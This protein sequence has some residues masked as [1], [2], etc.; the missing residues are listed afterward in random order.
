MTHRVDKVTGQL[1]AIAAE[2]LNRAAGTQSVVTVTHCEMP[3]DLKTAK[4]FISVFPESKE[5]EAL[6]FARRRRSELREVIAEKLPLKNLPF[7]EIEL[8]EGEKNR[9]KIDRLLAGR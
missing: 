4:I 9:Q 3:A 7:I 1:Q 8:D 2:F 6:H 5:E